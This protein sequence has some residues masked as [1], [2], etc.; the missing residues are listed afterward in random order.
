M[1]GDRGVRLRGVLRRP[2]TASDERNFESFDSNGEIDYR[3]SM[4]VP[5]TLGGHV[6]VGLA[7]IENGVR[8][9]YQLASAL[10]LTR[11]LAQCGGNLGA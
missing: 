10:T 9:R 8:M 7:G 11:S 4:V 2:P 5:Q 1:N 6:R 3:Q